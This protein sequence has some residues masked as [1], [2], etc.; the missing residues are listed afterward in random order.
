MSETGQRIAELLLSTQS[1]QVYDERPFVFVSGRVSPVYIDCRRLLS[2]PEARDEILEALAQIARRD[3]GLDNM[4][5]VA[6][7]ETAGIPYAAFVSHYLRKPM[8]YIRKN[9]KGYG[10]TNQIEGVLDEG[11]RVTLVEDLVTDGFSKLRFNIGV[12]AQKAQITHC[13]C[14]F[15][16][17]SDEL[18]L[19]EG[20]KNLADHDISLH[21]LSNWDD[22]L[23]AGEET[24]FFSQESRNQIVD[25]LKDPSNWGRRMGFE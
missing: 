12:R 4:D 20:K 15:E 1:I 24:Q 9:P 7:G 22:V 25:F 6:G 13:L 17:S 14:V 10:Q 18:D 23:S 3:I 16:Y 21:T 5:V 8:I 2:F 19:H 11:Q